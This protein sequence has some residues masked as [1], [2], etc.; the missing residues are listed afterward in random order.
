MPVS[1]L[2]MLSITIIDPNFLAVSLMFITVLIHCWMFGLSDLR[3]LPA[4]SLTRTEQFKPELVAL[5]W[6]SGRWLP[7]HGTGN[8]T[9]QIKLTNTIKQC[10]TVNGQLKLQLF[11]QAV[12]KIRLWSLK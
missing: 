5:D 1:G 6:K 8:T 9:A 11:T 7:W 4:C 3:A 10:N 12:N 2:V